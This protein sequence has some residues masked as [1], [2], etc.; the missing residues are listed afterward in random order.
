MDDWEHI[1]C[2]G[3]KHDWRLIGCTQTCKICGLEGRKE[4][5][6][7]VPTYGPQ[8]YH[9]RYNVYSRPCR[10]AEML[11]TRVLKHEDQ[12]KIMDSFY[13]LHD[14]WNK[15]KSRSSR[16]FYNRRV[17]TSYFISVHFATQRKKQLKNQK[18][19]KRQIKEIKFLLHDYVYKPPAEMI[20]EKTIWDLFDT[21]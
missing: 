9:R 1:G 14:N 7:V 18:S 4:Y 5:N 12:R 3:E 17:C 21:L 16:Y 20:P 11:E 2:T 13:T 19:E 6:A 10:F 15:W 8:S